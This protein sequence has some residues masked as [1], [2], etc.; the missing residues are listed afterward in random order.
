MTAIPTFHS[1]WAR[2][3]TWLLELPRFNKRGILVALDLLLLT[4]AL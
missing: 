4:I 1:L 2:W 3:Q